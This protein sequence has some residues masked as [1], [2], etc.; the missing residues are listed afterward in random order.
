MRRLLILLLMIVVPLKAWASVALPLAAGMAHSGS[1]TMKHIGQMAYAQAQHS[2]HAEHAGAVSNE[3]CADHAAGPHSHEC[4]HLTT[5][6]LMQ[7]SLARTVTPGACERAAV[8]ARPLISVVL[9][10]LLPPPLLL[11]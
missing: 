1:L 9:D 6:L 8:A 11:A 5:P 4:P 10:V 2:D 7:A 3:C